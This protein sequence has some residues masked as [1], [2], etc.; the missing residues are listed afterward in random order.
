MRSGQ[1]GP[2]DLS[3]FVIATTN[4]VPSTGTPASGDELVRRSFTVPGKSRAACD[5]GCVLQ[6]HAGLLLRLCA[7]GWLRSGRLLRHLFRGIPESG[8]ALAAGAEAEKLS[9]RDGGSETAR[10]KGKGHANH[11][12]GQSWA[13][14]DP[15]AEAGS[16]T[17]IQE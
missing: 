9:G 14:W 6:H 15:S 7:G 10:R 17:K 16:P 13:W 2:L 5:Y 8:R 1:A 4:S 11:L 12:A 3:P